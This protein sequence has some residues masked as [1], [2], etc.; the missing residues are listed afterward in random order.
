MVPA[1][2]PVAV[3]KVPTEAKKAEAVAKDFE[4]LF[5][6]Q[7]LKQMRQPGSGSGGMFGSD[8]ADVYGGLFDFFMGKHLADAGGLGLAA[9]IQ[10][11]LRA[12]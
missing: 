5:V 2:A 11:Q 4:S 12:S 9:S 7:L 8:S 3:G 6:S 1:L 10:A